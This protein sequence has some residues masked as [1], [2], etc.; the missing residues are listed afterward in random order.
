ML[1]SLGYWASLVCPAHFLF[2]G[3]LLLHH[4][5]MYGRGIGVPYDA[6]MVLLHDVECWL[7]LYGVS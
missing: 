1:E 3:L 2:S 4:L 7:M 6:C 5:A